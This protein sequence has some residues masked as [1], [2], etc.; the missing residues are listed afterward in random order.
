MALTLGDLIEEGKSGIFEAPTGLGKS[1]AALIPA[2]ANA[3]STNQRTVIATYTNVLAEQY[4]QKDLPFALGIFKELGMPEVRTGMLMG[5][6]RYVCEIALNDHIPSVAAMYLPMAKVGNESEFRR[7]SG[8]PPR[9]VS[10]HWSKIAVPPVCPG[11][12]CEAYERCLYYR[13]RRQASK[14]KVVIT[15]HSVVIQDALMKSMPDSEGLLG[16]YDFLIL[17]EVH[18]FPSA[19]QNGLEF[20]VSSG[21]MTSL[22]GIAKR[23]ESAIKPVVERLGEQDR[24]TD[25]VEDLQRELTDCQFSLREL[26]L[27]LANAAI[28]EIAPSELLEHP[29]VNRRRTKDIQSAKFLTERLKKACD[30]F[31]NSVDRVV[32]TCRS[33]D[34]DSVEK[35]GETIQNYRG[36]ITEFGAG[37]S[38]M[39]EPKGVAVTYSGRSGQD[40]ILRQDIVDLSGP[41]KELIWERGAY[42]C[43]SGT[44]CVDGNFEFFKS[45]TGATPDFEEV[46]PSAFDYG[47]SA[48]LYLPKL[49]RIPDPSEAR[50]SGTESAYFRA[51][52]EV[53]TEIISAVGGKTL[54]LFHSRREMEEVARLLQLPEHLPILVQAPS[55]VS[56]IGEKFIARRE[57]SLL[58]LRSFWTGFD[59]PGETLS[60]VVLVRIPFEVPIDPPQIARLAYLQSQGRNAFTYHTLPLAKMMMRQGAGRLLRRSDDRGLVAIIDPRVRSKQYGEDI[61]DNLP[62][63]MRVFDDI[64]DAVGYVGLAD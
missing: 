11:R 26:N 34:P 2:I 33:K 16:D 27:T 28:L 52:A 31:V 7:M 21:K 63:G 62:P 35:V 59:A 23:M 8:L 48:G 41:L 42:A 5:R 43:M 45:V 9:Q 40:A 15:N 60:C 39:F 36:Y 50:K 51:V 61:L 37:A 47:T 1:L 25:A 12:F 53:L 56:A 14:A 57:S 54:A 3:I 32:E 19:A 55:G 64:G 44:L 30:S 20:E 6:Q 13:A 49:K 10:A 46:F 38:S 17:D 4:W 29:E 24:L 18:D 58:G 22:A